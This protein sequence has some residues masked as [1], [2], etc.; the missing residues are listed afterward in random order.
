MATTIQTFHPW[1]VGQETCPLESG[2][3]HSMVDLQQQLPA[4]HGNGIVVQDGWTRPFRFWCR[5]GHW[6][7]I[8]F[9][10]DGEPGADY[11]LLPELGE[12]GDDFVLIDGDFGAAPEHVRLSVDLGKQRRTMADIRSVG[13]V[14]E[15]FRLDNNALPGGPVAAL[16]PVQRIE[17]DVQPI[18]I[19]SL[20]L[21]DAWGNALRYW[22]DGSSS[23]RIVSAGADGVLE[24]DYSTVPGS[25]EFDATDFGRDIVFGDG[26]FEQWPSDPAEEP[27]EG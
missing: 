4:G 27:S 12:T 25:G 15:A 16:E 10:A 14:F 2:V 23:Y 6:A 17:I 9:G 18:Y 3:L 21:F 11:A 20:P 13:I 8:S 24:T 5:D 19:R 1:F 7:V 26:E 22:T